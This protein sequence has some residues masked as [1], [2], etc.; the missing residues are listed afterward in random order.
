MIADF[1]KRERLRTIFCLAIS[2]STSFLMI[3]NYYF[4]YFFSIPASADFIFL[5]DHISDV[6]GT[7]SNNFNLNLVLLLL[8]E[9]IMLI[10]FFCNSLKRTI[11]NIDSFFLLKIRKRVIIGCTIV[12]CAYFLNGFYRFQQVH[13]P[14]G[15]DPFFKL[16]VL[17][18]YPYYA[19][20]LARFARSSIWGAKADQA[21]IDDILRQL[22]SDESKQNRATNIPW[23]K[24]AERPN[25]VFIQIESL[26]SE[27][28]DLV[29][30]GKPVTPNLSLL[31]QKSLFFTDFYAQGRTTSDCDFIALNSLLVP[32]NGLIVSRPGNT[33]LSIAGILR[34]YG[35]KTIALN[36]A[37]RKIWNH[38]KMYKAYGFNEFYALEDFPD[39]ESFG[40]GLSDPAIFKQAGKLME[41]TDKPFFLFF[42]TLS[43][44][45]PFYMPD[46]KK[47][48]RANTSDPLANSYLESINYADSSLGGFIEFL[49]SSEIMKNT[50]VFIYGD[51]TI[52]M[53]YFYDR[54]NT[55]QKPN[56]H[57][58]HFLDSRTPLLI[59]SPYLIR[60]AQ[61][62]V[63]SGQIDLA[64]T[65]LDLCDISQPK[66]FLGHS[67]FA[68]SHPDAVVNF[69]G[70]AKAGQ[71]I[72][73]DYEAR[74][75][76]FASSKTLNTW[77]SAET[78]QIADKLAKQ[79]E[80]SRLLVD[81]NLIGS[82]IGLTHA[83]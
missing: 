12:L 4:G 83:N 14:A 76:T 41:K 8:P 46:S 10:S 37:R 61:I 31:A 22:S 36:G 49:H 74:T 6:T 32:Q 38:E 69:Q 58:M 60:P 54:I 48:I 17:G 52:R 64:P 72:L 35:Y 26:K 24:K 78:P 55:R 19:E 67:L 77:E 23:L 20:E 15:M 80:L 57:T 34:D 3:T 45:H 62:P 70:I 47:L 44:H 30:E 75:Q 66:V 42:T 82:I 27:V 7:I 65:V 16:M 56:L 79:L 43:S 33:F 50:V 13:C 25:I 11:D 59:Y 29:I 21:T 68:D 73:Y 53:D 5:I 9:F 2:L 40:L 63:T 71:H 39:E 81:F 28:L 18:P 51:H 1:F